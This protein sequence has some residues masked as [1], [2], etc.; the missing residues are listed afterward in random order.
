M[1]VVAVVVQILHGSIHHV[2]A[3][4]RFA[5]LEGAFDHAP[6]QQIAHFHAVERLALAGLHE[7]VLDDGVRIAV[8]HDLQTAAKFVGTVTGHRPSVIMLGISTRS[9]AATGAQPRPSAD[10]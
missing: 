9:D 5:G 2:G 6:G 1:P 8:E 4:D 7:L 10:R 3:L